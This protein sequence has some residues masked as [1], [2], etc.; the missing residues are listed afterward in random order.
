MLYS[1]GLRI[2]QLCTSPQDRD[3]RL[4]EL[5]NLLFEKNYPERLVKSAINKARAVPRENALRT[6]IIKKEK[7]HKRPVISIKYD[8]RVPS[9]TN[10]QS[11]H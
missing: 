10:L 3:K 5:K 8:P 2:V 1:L 11:K 6:V 7:A 9:V 4:N